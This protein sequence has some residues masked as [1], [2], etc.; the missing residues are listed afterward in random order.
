MCHPIATMYTLL[1]ETLTTVQTQVYYGLMQR[2]QL[3]HLY[4]SS[5]WGRGPASHF[6][7]QT[8]RLTA[9]LEKLDYVYQILSP[10]KHQCSEPGG[11]Q[12]VER[13]DQWS[14]WPKT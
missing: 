11:T 4:L 14:E 3:Q 12:T 9:T 5:L 13:A 8:G 7:P 6:F 2:H 10:T 1:L